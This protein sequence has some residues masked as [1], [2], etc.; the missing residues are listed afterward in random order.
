MAADPAIEVY[1]HGDER[2]RR[3]LRVLG[4]LEE[5]SLQLGRWCRRL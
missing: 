5:V 2:E 4:L 1:L 3:A